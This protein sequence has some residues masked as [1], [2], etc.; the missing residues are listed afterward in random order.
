MKKILLLFLFSLSICSAQ[1]IVTEAVI[2]R[3]ESGTE[4]LYNDAESHLNVCEICPSIEF[5]QNFEYYWWSDVDGVNKS[6]GKANGKLI[7]GNGL[8]YFPNGNLALNANYHLGLRNGVQRYW[9]ESGKLVATIKFDMGVQTYHRSFIEEGGA[10]EQE[11]IGADTDMIGYENNIY[12]NGII[13]LKEINLDNGERKLF[14]Y[15]DSGELKIIF[16]KDSL[17]RKIRDYKSYYKN[18]NIQ[19]SGSFTNGNKDGSWKYFNEDGN[20]DNLMMYL[21]LT[22]KFRDDKT[23][24]AKGGLYFDSDNSEWI[25]HGT[26]WFFDEKGLKI[27]DTKIYEFGTEQKD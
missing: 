7:H 21:G 11:F 22:V 10:M 20:L 24:F 16:T 6:K 4:G 17:N 18:G 1:E 3:I 2:Y 5:K 23:I 19:S 26:W 8:W 9:N 13:Q 15:S 12:E 25:K 14:V 27:I